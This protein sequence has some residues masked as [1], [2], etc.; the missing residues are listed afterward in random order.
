MRPGSRP[1]RYSPLSTGRPCGD[2]GQHSSFLQ[3]R[4]RAF[5]ESPKHQDD[6]WLILNASSN[7]AVVEVYELKQSSQKK[8]IYFK[9]PPV[10]AMISL[11]IC[12]PT[13]AIPVDYI[14]DL[15]RT[16]HINHPHIRTESLSSHI[17]LVG[18][19][20]IQGSLAAITREPTV[21]LDSSP[22]IES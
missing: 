10:P 11:P 3:L 14:V 18:R 20:T 13:E 7:L 8:E 21:L 16:L 22:T 9:D 4:G 5:G 15:P 1:I 12:C 2:R 19:S 17:V 6:S